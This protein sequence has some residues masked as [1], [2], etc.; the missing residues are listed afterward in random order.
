MS[1][2]WILYLL[3]SMLT[4]NPLVALVAL[5]VI[6][7]IADRFT[8]GFLPSP[9]RILGRWGRVQ[10]LRQTLLVNP[11]DRR[12]RLEL[13]ELVVASSP[14]E[15]AQVLRSNLEAGDQD[16]HTAFIYGKALARSG[17]HEEAERSLSFAREIEPNFRMG[18]IDL[19][20]G[21]L[22]MARGD[23]KGA[24]EPLELFIGARP[25]TVEGRYLL[26]RVL[27]KLGDGAA[28]ERIQDD[29]WREYR[30]LPRFRRSD[31]RRFAWRLRPVRAAVL[32]AAIIA[33][34]AVVMA[35]VA[36]LSS[37]GTWH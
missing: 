23:W 15:A 10:R 9:A 11:H 32:F 12:A 21:R 24:R 37:A 1:T 29:A 2:S 19:E 5:L 13:A 7:W 16:V 34:A 36:R 25:G 8:F 17:R 28:A 35:S 33:M 22:R 26:A 4:G 6:G 14:R 31:E 30:S 3:L 20:L 27:S 18:E